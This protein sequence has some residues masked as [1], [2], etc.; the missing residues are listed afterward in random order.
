MFWKRNAQDCPQRVNSPN[1][2]V[3]KNFHIAYVLTRADDIG[4][5][6]IHV[7]DLATELK[8]RGCRVSVISGPTGPFSEQLKARQIDFYQLRALRRELSPWNDVKA[9]FELRTLLS[10]LRPEIVSTHCSKAGWVGRVAARMLRIPVIYTPHGWK[11]NRV[12]T[13][14]EQRLYIAAE[15]FASSISDRIITVSNHGRRIAID[16]RVA[17]AATLVCIHNGIRDRFLASERPNAT[18]NNVRLVMTAR[19]S[20]P[21][22]HA[23]LLKALHDVGGTDWTL[24]LIG[25]GP[26]IQES[27]ALACSLGIADQVNFLGLRSDVAE[28]LANCDIFVLTTKSEGF[29]RTILEAMSAKLPVVVSD[30]GGVAES[31]INGETGFLVKP[32]DHA[33]LVNK[34]SLLIH[35]PE[36]RRTLGEAGRRSYQ[37][38]FQFETMLDKTMSL[39]QEVLAG[40][41]IV[42]GS[43]A[44]ELRKL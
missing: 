40:S 32:G 31:V 19:F 14:I 21:K 8:K 4:G 44:T 2:G 35:D 20:E 16:E 41:S 23:S 30:V 13:P 1:S 18:G 33:A 25:D 34:I 27:K 28:I 37:R 5:A 15:R 11:F 36:L 9:I 38:Q 6:Q 7:L 10:K 22:D 3:N 17:K 24:E 43:R 26:K 12:G 39:Y 29:P 42:Q